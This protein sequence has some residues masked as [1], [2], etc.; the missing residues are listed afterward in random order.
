MYYVSSIDGFSRNTW[1]YFLHNKYLVFDKFKEFKALVE[2][3]GDKKVKLLRINN[4][5]EFHG[6][7]IEEICKKS[8]I[9]RKIIVYTHTNIMELRKR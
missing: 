9:L 3:Q 1:V 7:S 6:N 2:N 5:G 8:G 4:I